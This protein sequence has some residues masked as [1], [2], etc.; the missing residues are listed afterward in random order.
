M[1]DPVNKIQRKIWLYAGIDQSNQSRDQFLLILLANSREASIFTLK[2][3]YRI[4][5]RSLSSF[6]ARRGDGFDVSAVGESPD[7]AKSFYTQRL[8]L[9]SIKTVVK[10]INYVGEWTRSWWNCWL[11]KQTDQ[12]RL[13][14]AQIWPRKVWTFSLLYFHC[15]E[16]KMTMFKW[17][18]RP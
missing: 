15:Y 16:I 13:F 6:H 11:L 2:F 7:L 8:N 5:S 1:A 17:R 12:L 9:V 4:G 14:L 18:K 10:R 3:L